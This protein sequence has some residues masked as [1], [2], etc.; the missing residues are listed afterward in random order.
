MEDFLLYLQDNTGTCIAILTLL[1]VFV[2]IA[3]IKMNPLSS[4]IRWMSTYF[5]KDTKTQLDLI[6]KQLHHVSNRID[7]IEINDM[8]SS[9]LDFANSCMH[10]KKHTKEEFEHIIDLHT[11]YEET[12]TEKGMKNGRVD[13]AFQYISQQYTKCLKENDF[14]DSSSTP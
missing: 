5:N 4:F 9:I 13:L 8:R 14:L 12:L 2:E 6:T 10:E 1:S 7:I 3:P 11:Q